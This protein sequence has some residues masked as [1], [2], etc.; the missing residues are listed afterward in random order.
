MHWIFLSIA[1]IFE[2]IF[3]LSS[4]AAKGFTRFWPS[5]LT[6]AAAA[7]GI[8]TL[9]QALKTLDVSVGYTIWT[10]VGSV[11]TVI[12]GILLFGEKLHALKLV[13]FVI[14]ITGV[15]GLKFA[16]GV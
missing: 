12:F 16:S 1:C 15:V 3:A 7:G 13:S 6:L 14:I 4:N 5:V 10:G 9:S 2:V 11:G 8:Y